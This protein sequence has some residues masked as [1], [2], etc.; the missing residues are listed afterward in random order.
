LAILK[1][2]IKYHFIL[3]LISPILALIY[4]IRTKQ[5]NY[6]RWSVF[7]FVV[8]YG[9][10]MHPSHLGDGAAHFEEVAEQSLDKNFNEFWDELVS[11]LILNPKS[12]TSIDPFI[13]ILR[14]I[15]GT[16]F[17]APRFLFIVVSIIFGFF[18]SGSI[19][20][21]LDYVSWDTKYNKFYFTI[22]LVTLIL[23]QTPGN[24]QSI[25][26]G[27]ALWIV[28]YSIVSYH[29]S[30]KRKYLTIL[31]LAPCFH[32]AY[33][34]LSIPFLIVLFSNYRN[35]KVYFII[36]M[37][38][39]IASNVVNKEAVNDLVSQNRVGQGK[40]KGYTM[41]EERL[42]ELEAK[43]EEKREESNI[44]FYRIYETENI[45]MNVL[46]GLIIFVFFVLKN[47][48]FG[49]LEN[50]LFS[51]GLAGASFANFLSFNFAVYNR[52]W[53]LAGIFILSLVVIFLSKQNLRNIAFS[54]L[55][56]RLPLFVFS[57]LILPYI[58]YLLSANLQFTPVYVIFTP[59]VMWFDFDIGMSIRG[60]IGI[61]IN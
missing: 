48:G 22:F 38:S 58:L 37:V 44:R 33:L 19:V 32:L 20:K 59:F 27:T 24:M 25:R 4:G 28:I 5:R 49:Y 52:T 11:I 31:L 14:F 13:H 55:K 34:V 21:L 60:F 45:H 51:Y 9:S 23:W 7:I 56:V 30:N 2:N 43:R 42:E 54:F 39:V 40:V 41:D 6:I 18:Y 46:T 10:T 15:L 8:I 3:Y 29:Q 12:E 36:F 35:P 26:Q 47:R 57:I 53:Q 50:T 16:L 61:L 17:D 1:E